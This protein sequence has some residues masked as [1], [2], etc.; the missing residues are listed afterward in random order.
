MVTINERER[1]VVEQYTPGMTLRLLEHR[2]GDERTTHT[3]CTWSTG[4]TSHG[5]EGIPVGSCMV[6]TEDFEI[7]LLR[8]TSE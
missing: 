1:F 6:D 8:L 7:A 5:V 2:P 3:E 4:T